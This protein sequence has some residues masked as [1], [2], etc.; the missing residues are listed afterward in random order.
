LVVFDTVLS[1]EAAGESVVGRLEY[2]GNIGKGFLVPTLLYE[3]GSGQ[4]QKREYT[5]VEVAAGQGLYYWNDYNG[6][7]VQQANEFEIGIYPDQKK[8]VRI[9]TPTNEYVKVNYVTLNHSLLV[10]PESLFG[11]KPAKGLQQF[12]SRFS[13]QLSLQISNRALSTLGFRVFNPFSSAIP[14]E[15]LLANSTSISNTFFFNRSSAKWGAEYTMS[16]NS[17]KSLL[18]YGVE[19]NGQNRN[20]VKLRWNITKSLTINNITQTGQR[21]YSSALED[22]RTYDVSIKSIEP[23]LT[24]ILRSTFRVTGSYRYEDRRNQYGAGGEHALIRSANIDTRLSFPASGSIQ[25]RGTYAIIGYNGLP[26]T[27]LSFIMLDALQQGSNW[28]WYLNWER[29]ISKGIE[30]SLEYEGRKPGDN[31]IIHTGRMSVR[32]VL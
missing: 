7:G 26:N 16:Y 28:L 32:A 19:G 15:M 10:N 25:A 6:D 24:W 30:I 11:G 12:I 27:S 20:T 22:G 9:I 29:R 3:A 21:R 2:N 18:T 8:F 13:N 17:G 14:D 1:T 4:E 5:Y 23:A 31:Q